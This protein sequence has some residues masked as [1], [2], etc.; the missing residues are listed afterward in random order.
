M[1]SSAIIKLNYLNRLL[2]A[3]PEMKERF[4][5]E[6]MKTVEEN[7]AA[8]QVKRKESMCSKCR[9]PITQDAWT[10]VSLDVMARTA[11][12]ALEVLYPQFYLDPK[13]QSHA[14]MFGIERRLVRKDGS[15]TYKE[16]SEEE[17]RFALHLGH[18]LMV[19]LLRMQNDYFKLGFDPEVQKRIDAFGSVWGETP[20]AAPEWQ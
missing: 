10:R 14:N 13:A 5:D 2:K 20:S 12:P 17:A 4:N 6:F 3:I 9:Q 18:H 16:I 1:E 19:R 15:T 8:A 11:E 7:A